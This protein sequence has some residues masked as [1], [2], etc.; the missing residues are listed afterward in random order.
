MPASAPRGVVGAAYARRRARIPTYGLHVQVRPNVPAEKLYDKAD[1][2]L[3]TRNSWA[4][5][6]VLLNPPF[7]SQVRPA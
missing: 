3:A 1:D 6:H 7:T 2:G 4:G 5:Y